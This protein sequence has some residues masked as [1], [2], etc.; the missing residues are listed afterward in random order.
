MVRGGDDA[1]ASFEKFAE[2]VAVPRAGP[3]VD[4][5]LAP[6]AASDTISTFPAAP[7]AAA[8][9]P[10]RIRSKNSW[11]V[12]IGLTSTRPVAMREMTSG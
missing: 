11:W 5:A 6:S 1:Q 3:S 2:G 12:M 7:S 4:P 10:S 9:R 8:A